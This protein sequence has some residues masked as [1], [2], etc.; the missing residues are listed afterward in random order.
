MLIDSII[1]NGIIFYVQ[2]FLVAMTMIYFIATRKEDLIKLKNV[3][4]DALFVAV[5]I[6]IAMGIFSSK[7]IPYYV[8]KVIEPGGGL[9]II[10]FIMTMVYIKLRYK[11]NY[12]FVL[13]ISFFFASV[14]VQ[15]I[16]VYISL[17]IRSVLFPAE[18][19]SDLSGLIEIILT[20]I[21]IPD[22]FLMLFAYKANKWMSKN[23]FYLSKRDQ[24]III[25]SN[26]L[27]LITISVLD[28]ILALV[29]YESPKEIF[30]FSLINSKIFT[31]KI[32]LLLFAM[33]NMYFY[34]TTNNLQRK[35]YEK[36]TED[37]LKDYSASYIDKAKEYSEKMSKL[38]HDFKNHIMV[39]DS[40]SDNKEEMQKYIEP[41]LKNA[42]VDDIVI[43]GNKLADIVLNEKVEDMKKY[44][45]EYD[46]KAA[47]P[48]DISI[49][50]YD[51]TSILFN[52]IDN[53]IEASSHVDGER[54]IYIDIFSK[55][56][57]LVY[58][59]SNNYVENLL[60]DRNYADK[61]KLKRGIGM[62]LVKDIVE[63]YKGDVDISQDK[64]IYELR[65]F[66]KI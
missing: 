5:F 24:I 4:I 3:L 58:N 65:L 51:L 20:W 32:I 43:T 41:L 11:T 61:P 13:G 33:L 8:I 31:I 57:N 49:D 23:G 45:I 12:T 59:I 46:I 9:N 44:N 64:G 17:S 30:S 19:L 36:D 39:L 55:G 50:D 47:I 62:K 66:I 27:L 1:E 63:K 38:V 22:V 6:A 54:K 42:K 25:T 40:L 60:G 18:N 28:G 21:V 48:P 53:A 15:L 52:T 56:N 37:I 26:I 35:L 10:V 29:A 14:I 2:N 7:I 16:V 34:L